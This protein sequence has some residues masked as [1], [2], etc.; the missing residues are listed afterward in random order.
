MYGL[1]QHKDC[2]IARFAREKL[3]KNYLKWTRHP[4]GVKDGAYGRQMG[5]IAVDALKKHAPH[6]AVI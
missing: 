3:S 6:T 5:P 1:P 4:M 2:H